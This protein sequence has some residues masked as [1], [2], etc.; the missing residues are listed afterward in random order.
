MNYYELLEVSPKASREVITSA[1][2]ALSKKYHPDKNVGDSTANE[3]MALVNKAFEVLSNSET[4]DAY[5]RELAGSFGA[6]S[7]KSGARVSMNH[8][9]PNTG[10]GGSG[11]YAKLSTEKV[12]PHL[13]LSIFSIILIFVIGFFVAQFSEPIETPPNEIKASSDVAQPDFAHAEALLKGWGVPRNYQLALQEYQ[14][15]ANTYTSDR[16][17]AAHRIADIY[18]KGLGVRQDYILAAAWYQKAITNSSYGSEGP[19]PAYVGID[20]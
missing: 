6:A 19:H 7:S 4:R 13:F 9:R 17:H 20:V 18:Y 3:M 2:R 10:R 16:G 8:I 5:D 14:E 11:E 1:Y 15:L 12:S